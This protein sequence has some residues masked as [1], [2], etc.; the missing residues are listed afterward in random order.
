MKIAPLNL[1]NV[2]QGVIFK[3]KTPNVD[4]LIASR[5][6]ANCALDGLWDDL[7]SSIKKKRPDIIKNIGGVEYVPDDTLLRKVS[8]GFKTVDK[9]GT[10]SDWK[11]NVITYVSPGD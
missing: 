11:T 2:R 8:S 4:D 7:A 1:N 6:F 5:R 9:Q 10:T 3:G